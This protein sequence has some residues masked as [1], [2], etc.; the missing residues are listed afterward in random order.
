MKKTQGSSSK[1]FEYSKISNMLDDISKKVPIIV[2]KKDKEIDMLSTG[3]YALNACLSG[4]IYGGIQGDRITVFAG[5]EATG[6]S[7][8]ALNICREAQ[9]K[10]YMIFYIDTENSL[11]RSD[12]AKYGIDNSEE[13]FILIKTN[14][15][16]D[17][18]IT[19]SQLLDEF[20]SQKMQGVELPKMLMVL[21]SVG[22]LASNK[23][24]EDLLKGEIK[25]DMT[26]A[27][28]LGS[29]FRSITIDLG[30]LEIPLI[31][32]NQIY[33]TMDMFPKA[34]MKGG[35]SLYYSASNITFLT[36]AKLKTG[37]ED[38]NDIGQS[39]IIVTAKAMKN[40]MCKPKKVKFEI[41]FE[42]GCNPFIGLDMFLQPQF[43]QYTGVAKG[44][45]EVDKSTGE[46]KFIEGG[47]RWYVRH[48]GKHVATKS[49][50]TSNVFNQD[51]LNGI[52]K[53][54]KEYFKYKSREELEQVE[55]QFEDIMNQAD[56]MDY[57]DSDFDGLDSS[58]LFDLNDN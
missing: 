36:K 46:E 23:E 27:K 42:T 53:I 21:D 11:K 43:Y 30:Y 44:K 31:V 24:K 14:K 22:Q 18:N 45:V 6:K 9:R 29:L 25:Q 15:I 52:D 40:R 37:E 7:F 56:N 58:D 54:A 5:E 4:S 8:L 35:K 28:A 10:G 55:K 3:I 12:L 47:N 51:V 13:K 34:V 32:N 33:E 38:E 16:E 2:E 20:K 50:F 41:S 39:G 26:K 49:L 17:I 1:K 57:K 48:L 19:I